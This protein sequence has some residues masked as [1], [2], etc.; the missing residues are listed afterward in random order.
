MNNGSTILVVDD[1]DMNLEMLDLILTT[2]DRRIIKA[3][4][5]LQAIRALEENPEV[6]VMLVDLEMPVMDGTKFISIIKQSMQYCEIPVIV[7][8]GNSSEVTRVLSM[9][10]SDFIAKPYNREELQLRVMNQVRI[11]KASDLAKYNLRKSEARL[12]QLLQSTDQG[13]Y[14]INMDG[15][16]TFINKP[17]LTIL[18]FKAE[19]CIGKNIHD[20]IHHSHPDGSVYPIEDCSAYKAL[21]SSHNYRSD[22]EVLWRKD[23]TSFPADFSSNP[24]I[25]NDTIYGAVVTFS[26]ITDKKK[27]D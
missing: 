11:K 2:A 21:L 1:D 15:S 8:T 18:G 24:L 12:E 25:E 10:A 14:S 6:D 7:L 3:G 13:I 17:G 16:C 4:D 26:D 5:G 27:S 23:G 19:D 20:L 9:G 22:N